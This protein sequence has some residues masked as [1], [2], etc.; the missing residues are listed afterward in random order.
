MDSLRIL[1]TN[2][3]DIFGGGEF[4][5]LELAEFLNNHGQQVWVSC[6]ESSLLSEKC[7]RKKINIIHTDYPRDGKGKLIKSVNSLK[8]FIRLNKVRIVHTNTNYDRTAGAFAANLAGAAHIASIHS[9]LS[10]R[11]NITHWIRNRYLT[12][13]FI[14][15][16]ENIRKVLITKDKIPASKI[17]LIHPGIE[18]ELMKRNELLRERLRK[19]FCVEEKQVLIGNIG[20]M[21]DFKGQEYL[22][23]AFSRLAGYFPDARLMIVGSG[24]LKERL[25]FVS[26]S[27]GIKEKVIFPGFRDD[28]QAVYSAFDIY[29]HTSVEGGGELFP[30]AV[31][32]ALAASLPVVATPAGEIGE[33]VKDGINGFLVPEK[34]E[35]I[36][37]DKLFALAGEPDLRYIM[38]NA[39]N[40]LLQ[41]KFTLNSMGNS[42]L[43]LYNN[44]LRIT[45]NS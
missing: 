32:Y 23:H 9:L 19:E 39:G 33:M 11:H 1:L 41:E 6:I 44:V 7:R 4:F 5:V 8:R 14:A 40:K 10:I 30:F 16:G 29:A 45:N 2:A 21:V 27:L 26:E 42:I 34:N 43:K 18:P 35:Y 25:L 3:L 38:G 28:M 31:L 37:A 24:E 20:R 15:D 17:T 22:I 13:N 36:T 12:A